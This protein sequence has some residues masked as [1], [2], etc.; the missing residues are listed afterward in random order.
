MRTPRTRRT[1]VVFVGAL[2]LLL[3]D[4]AVAAYQIRETHQADAALQRAGTGIKTQVQRFHSQHAGYPKELH[5]RRGAVQFVGTT[6]TETNTTD[7]DPGVRLVWYTGKPDPRLST[8]S[9]ERGSGFAYCLSSHGRYWRLNAT[10]DA[11]A[12][13]GDADD[14][15]PSQPAR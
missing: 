15:C 2:T 6:T 7:L 8:S 14:R 12:T 13:R 5:L 1:I 11:I 3:T 9:Q 4:G 10:E